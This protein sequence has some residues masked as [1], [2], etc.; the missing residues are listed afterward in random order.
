MIE[1]ISIQSEINKERSESDQSN[2]RYLTWV[3]PSI[4]FI[5]TVL[6][7]SGALSIAASGDMD[8]ITSTLAR[9]SIP[10]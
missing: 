3:I 8:V 7:I 6:G 2:I 1:I 10:R 5:G 4:G 9:P